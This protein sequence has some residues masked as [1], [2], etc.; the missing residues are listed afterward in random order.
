MSNSAVKINT[1]SFAVWTFQS[2]CMVESKENSSKGY[3]HEHVDEEATQRLNQINKAKSLQDTKWKDP[4]VFNIFS[5]Y[6]HIP[7]SI[8]I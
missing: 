4:Y 1:F 5:C 6:I 8:F 7:V 3:L 2:S